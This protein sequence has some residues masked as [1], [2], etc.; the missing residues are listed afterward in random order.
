[1]SGVIRREEPTVVENAKETA[2]RAVAGELRGNRFSWAVVAEVSPSKGGG[3]A[4]GIKK[5]IGPYSA[6]GPAGQFEA[7]TR[8]VKPGLVAVY[9][10]YVGENGGVGS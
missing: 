3:I 4:Q 7:V 9:A 8:T 2:W 5:G 10:R 1:M 6:F